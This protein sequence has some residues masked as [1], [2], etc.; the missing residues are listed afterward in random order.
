MDA[1]A[2]TSMNRFPRTL[3]PGDV[4]AGTPSIGRRYAEGRFIGNKEILEMRYGNFG[5]G[6]VAARACIVLTMLSFGALYAAAQM[7]GG[8]N[9]TDAKFLDMM[10]KH[11]SNGVEMAGMGVDKANS[12]GVKSLARRIRDDQKK[13]IEEMEKMRSS[14]LSNMPKQTSM[15]M[16][17]RLMTMEM[18]DKMSQQDMAKLRAASGPAFDQTF[19]DVFM[20]HHQMA[21][22]MS[23]EEMSKGAH[24]EVKRKAREIVTKQSNELTEMKR[25]KTEVARAQSR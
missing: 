23:R 16:K 2:T 24:A 5:I 25:L 7:K 11:H 6:G 9:E 12:E 20:K 17:K 13:D 3:P 10:M 4:P 18:M 1:A 22:D 21:I 15:M 19:L 8:G 14:D